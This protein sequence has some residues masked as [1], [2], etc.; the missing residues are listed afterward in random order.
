MVPAGTG[1]RGALAYG[2]ATRFSRTRQVHG[3]FGAMWRIWGRGGGSGFFSG[4]DAWLWNERLRLLLVRVGV[5]KAVWQAFC[6]ERST[7]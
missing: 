3:R 7:R 5:S 4:M 2:R 6:K 1:W